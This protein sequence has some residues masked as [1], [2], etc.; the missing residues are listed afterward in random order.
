MQLSQNLRRDRVAKLNHKP[1]LT[2]PPTA[3][4]RQAV[5]MMQENRA[6]LVI[7]EENGRVVGVFTER[8]LIK[9][10]LGRGADIG[11]MITTVM[12]TQPTT[13]TVEDT[14]GNALQKMLDGG[15]RHL[16]V[17]DPRG[18]AVGRIS[19]REIV[20]YMVEYFPKAVYNL[21]PEPDQVQVAPEGA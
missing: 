11:A 12:T 13:V 1:A 2:L 8:D 17:V 15:Y 14:I 10:V 5:A 18:H 20:H 19:V 4:I 21:P 7:V 6:G 16:P 3:Q 9:R